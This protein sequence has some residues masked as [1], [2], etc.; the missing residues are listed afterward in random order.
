MRFV[1]FILPL[2]VL[3]CKSYS[4]KRNTKNFSSGNY[5]VLKITDSTY[6]DKKNY[7]ITIDTDNKRISGKFDCNTFGATYTLGED[8]FIDFGIVRATKM[9]C[10][11]NMITERKFFKVLS[12]IKYYTFE[13]DLLMF[14]S[15]KKSPEVVKL[16]K[17]NDE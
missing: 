12:N 14:Y 9:Y 2:F 15:E 1:F 11:G 17:I 6:S 3:S 4:T 16:K 5:E 13:K 10:N 8:N 7:I